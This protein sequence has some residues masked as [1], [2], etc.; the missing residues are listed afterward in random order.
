MGFDFALARGDLDS[1]TYQ[2][3]RVDLAAELRA[4]ARVV[5]MDEGGRFAL[6]TNKAEAGARLWS[7]Q[8]LRAAGAGKLRGW[9]LGR[10][11][12]RPVVSVVL[13]G[14]EI[15]ALAPGAEVFW[16]ELIDFAP[17]LGDQR[18]SLLATQSAALFAWAA[19]TRSCQLCGQAVG[20]NSGGW[21]ATCSS[22]GHVDYPRTDPAV[23]AAV[24]DPG[25]RL[26]LVHNVAW[27]PLRMSLP[28]G[29]VDAGESAERAV[30]REMR[31][32]VS[33]QVGDLRYLGSQPWPRPRSLMLAFAARTA[34][35]EP[36]ADGVEIDRAR[37]FSRAE[38][39]KDLASGNLLVPGP[40][41]VAHTV[42]QAWL[43]GDL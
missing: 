25:D 39:R 19:R 26:L 6:T 20:F 8:A 11:E 37:F 36:V 31:E 21:T 33:L 9:F 2:R 38:L 13:S 18:D 27:E 35:T 42:I 1:A 3:D 32:E 23:I 17:H 12:G 40:A 16:G 34:D 29:Y 43:E 24:T 14:T 30:R 4:D 41:A 15:A 22:C 7:P 5:V 28:A 10:E